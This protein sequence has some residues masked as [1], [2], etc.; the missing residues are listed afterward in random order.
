MYKQTIA[1]L[2]FAL[3]S[4]F[5]AA[6][7]TVAKPGFYAGLDL[8]RSRLGLSGGDIDGAL[9]NQGVASSSSSDN[10]NTAYSINAGYRFNPNWG[11]EGA[12]TR[13]GE[14]NFNSTTAADTLSGKYKAS[15]LSLAGVGYWPLTA[16]WS[17]YG[18]AGLARTSTDLDVSSDTGATAVSNQS[19]SGT[20]FL[21]GAGLQYDFTSAYFAKAGWDH[22]NSVG[23]DMTGKGNIDVYSV[24]AGVR[25]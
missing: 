16:N 9:A 14:F 3:S 24:G 15:A 5:A 7:S 23:G 25:F 13:F 11:I 20:S 1:L 8:G 21:L 17:V 10:G 19:H 6:Q 4:G 22:F 12:Y 2:A 18:K